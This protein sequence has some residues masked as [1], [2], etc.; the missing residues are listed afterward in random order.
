[1]LEKL[2]ENPAFI[3]VI[4]VV[5]GSGLSLFGTVL[6]Q[7]I[8]SRKEQRHWKNQQVAEKAA[9]N[10]NEQK[11]EKEY[12]REIYQN[13]L[14]SLSVFIA[15]EDQK[16]KE[17]KGLQNIEVINDV[18]KWVTMLLL[19]HSNSDLDDALNSFIT[20]PEEREAMDLRKEII[21]LSNSEEGFFLNELK[22]QPK[23]SKESTDPDIR[24]IHIAINNDFRKQQLIEGV[25]ISQNY[26]F[27]FKLSTM[28][29]SQREKLSEI[30]FNSHKTI[31][32]NFSLSLPVD[33]KGAKQIHMSGKPWQAAL[34]PNTT[35][36]EVILS[37]WEK[38]FDKSYEEATKSLK[39]AQ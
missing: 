4:G 35:E 31:P 28:S 11:K 22:D 13:S 20:W 38:D 5:I 29:K 37:R 6:S 27:E 8:L 9:W 16:E 3:G 32:R 19:R 33:T 17:A 21:Q 12:L 7:I 2:L 34:D 18:H 26:Q 23:K 24:T 15:L 10:R 25:E 36:P 39:A 30:F 14:R 1:M